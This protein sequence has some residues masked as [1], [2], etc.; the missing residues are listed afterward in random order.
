LRAH[1][2]FDVVALARH[3]GADRWTICSTPSLRVARALPPVSSWT[4]LL[5]LCV[6]RVFFLAKFPLPLHAR[7]LLPI[8]FVTY[9]DEV[10]RCARRRSFSAHACFPSFG[11]CPLVLAV[12]YASPPLFETTAARCPLFSACP[13]MA[14]F[15]RFDVLGGSFSFLVEE[16]ETVLCMVSGGISRVSCSR[17][18]LLLFPS[19]F[20]FSKI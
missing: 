13:A 7:R 1:S 9:F 5:F 16:G 12:F 14:T 20:P 19:V 8:S 4:S 3:R 11:G 15:S 10:L 17:F 18:S 6:C 2:F